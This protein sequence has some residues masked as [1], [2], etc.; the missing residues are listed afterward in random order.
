MRVLRAVD[1]YINPSYQTLK[2]ATRFL[3]TSLLVVA[4]AVCCVCDTPQLAFMKS[5]REKLNNYRGSTA[6]IHKEIVQLG[7]SL[8]PTNS[9]GTETAV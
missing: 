2:M 7:T 8:P 4:M 9:E 3:I 1:Q 5:A 6:G